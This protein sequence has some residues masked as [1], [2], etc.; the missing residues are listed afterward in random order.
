VS[1]FEVELA[2]DGASVHASIDGERVA[3]YRTADGSGIEG[4]LGFAVSFGDVKVS[5]ASVQRLDRSAA[6]NVGPA[7]PA[8]FDVALARPADFKELVGREVRGLPRARAGTLCLWLQPSELAEGESLDGERAVQRCVER[9]RD[10]EVAAL[11]DELAAKLVVALPSAL[12]SEHD[13]RAESAIR[14]AVP[15]LAPKLVFVAHGP[16]TAREW[17]AACELRGLTDAHQSWLLFVDEVGTLR[18]AQ[19]FHTGK[20]LEAGFR[21]WLEVFRLR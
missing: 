15:E 7:F 13:A 21:R 17:V 6:W 8:A 14:A 16:P 4:Y 11:R 12:G 1:S 20:A 10:L 18:A 9:V 5:D 3:T 2:V 19:T